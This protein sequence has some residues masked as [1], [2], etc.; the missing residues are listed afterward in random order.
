M[1]DIIALLTSLNDMG[2]IDD[3]I[4]V[5]FVC[6]EDEI[7]DLNDIAEAHDASVKVDETFGNEDGDVMYDGVIFT[8]Y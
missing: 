2:F 4:T 6:H 8:E 5:N 1:S 7:D 3:E